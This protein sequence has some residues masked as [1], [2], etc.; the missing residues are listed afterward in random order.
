MLFSMMGGVPVF[1]ESEKS[2]EAGPNG[3]FYAYVPYT[4][5]GTDITYAFAEPKEGLVTLEFDV[6][7]L[8]DSVEG[9]ISFTTEAAGLRTPS[10]RLINI[11]LSEDGQFAA[12]DRTASKAVNE[13]PYSKGEVYH[14]AVTIDLA[15][16][17]YSATVNDEI[18][19]ENYQ[20]ANNNNISNIGLMGVLALSGE[21]KVTNI[22]EKL[23]GLVDNDTIGMDET[24]NPALVD[25]VNVYSV[26]PTHKFKKVQDVVA[27]LGPGDIVEVDGDAVYPAPIFIDRQFAGTK[28]KPITLK[29]ITLNG[30][31]PEIKAVN[32]LI[33]VEFH[34]NHYVFDNFEVS[35]NLGDVL[36]KY[37]GVEYT[38]LMDQVRPL[39][40]EITNKTVYRG[41]LHK[42]DD[43]VIRNSIIHDAVQGIL[44]H[45]EDSGSILV[46]YNEVYHNGVRNGHHNLYLSA[47]EASYPDSVARV[48]YNYI[49]DANAGNGLKTRARRN[50]VYYNWFENN[51]YQS[52]ELI[53]PDPNFDQEGDHYKFITTE[54]LRKIDPDFGEFSHR[55]DSDVVGN[56]IVHTRAHLVRIGGDGTSDMS[57]GDRVG[58][59]YGQSYG[60]YRFANNTFIDYEEDESYPIQAIRIEFGVESLELYNNVFYKPF[61]DPMVIIGENTDDTIINK[62]VWA[63]GSRQVRGANNWVQTDAINVPGEGE[64]TG[65]IRGNDP[66][67]VDASSA[68]RNYALKATSPLR[69]AGI[70]MDQTVATWDDW[71]NTLYDISRGSWP[72]D[73]FDFSTYIGTPVDLTNEDNAFPNPLMSV[74]FNVL[75]PK[76]LS[77]SPRTDG[78]G[79]AIGAFGGLKPQQLLSILDSELNGLIA[80]GDVNGPSVN[81]LT[82][83]LNQ[84]E[85][86][87]NAGRVKQ[88]AQHVEKFIEFVNN[89]PQKR[90]ISEDAKTK[91][92][93]KVEALANSLNNK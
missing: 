92:N 59:S 7:P 35:G 45:D 18:L 41:I 74:D 64:W 68:V 28:D 46:E 39:Q 44:G 40:N 57:Y 12:N 17:T 32:P 26:G 13:I 80:L 85:H 30:K 77:V 15:S 66:G 48:Q 65:T 70:S 82:N 50:E 10:E 76:T 16:K 75:D 54:K 2:N 49:H 83:R 84:V 61:G 1:A 62:A 33:M 78:E 87:L 72:V 38:N 43:L 34:A 52:L 71:E 5:N 88:A 3:D 23:V 29:G 20:F 4:P 24:N 91:L 73:E 25:G 53:G 55:E 47:D 11:M 81:Q 69:G 31:K 56:V 89:P 36:A 58:P 19:A 37:P 27:L 42:S 21:F 60:R 14:V 90:N 6:T 93:V 67:F 22:S 9:N 63:S 86:H 79:I 51:Y 8:A